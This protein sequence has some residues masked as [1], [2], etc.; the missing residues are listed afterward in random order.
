MED[1]PAFPVSSYTFL[2]LNE[3]K[4]R[5]FSMLVE[6]ATAVR[7]PFIISA[8]SSEGACIVIFT[9]SMTGLS[10]KRG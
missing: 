3:L 7:N 10:F 8:N 1:D 2:S 9:V 5:K 6:V 4:L